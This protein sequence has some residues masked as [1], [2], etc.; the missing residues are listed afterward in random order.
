MLVSIEDWGHI[1][2]ESYIKHIIPVLDDRLQQHPEL[3]F[4]QDGAPGHRGGETRAEIQ[5]RNMPIIPW[6]P[7]SPDLESNLALLK[8]RT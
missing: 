3:C 4:M 2:M 8:K 7:Y 6:P 5:R 1:T